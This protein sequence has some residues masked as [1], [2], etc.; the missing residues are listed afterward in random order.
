MEHITGVVEHRIDEF[1]YLVNPNFGIDQV[2]TNRQLLPV[3]I[4]QIIPTFPI[5]LP[6]NLPT[7][8]VFD[9]TFADD[10]VCVHPGCHNHQS[11]GLHACFNCHKYVCARVSENTNVHCVS[12]NTK[13]KIQT[14]LFFKS[15]TEVVFV[16][17]ATTKQ[18]VDHV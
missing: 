18:F 9:W 8:R 4:F 7:P 14:V 11:C 16:G 2:L 12:E 3:N 10:E 6:K 15:L 5:S 13:S 17:C 1:S